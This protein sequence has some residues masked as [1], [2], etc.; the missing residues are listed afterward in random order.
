MTTSAQTAPANKYPVSLEDEDDDIFPPNPYNLSKAQ[1]IRLIDR[2]HQA[3]IKANG[4]PDLDL[5][6]RGMV[7]ESIREPWTEAAIK[8]GMRRGSRKYGTIPC[9]RS[10]RGKNCRVFFRELEV[11]EWFETNVKPILEKSATH[12]HH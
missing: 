5:D 4:L 11:I 9:L 2:L 7:E 6:Y 12:I 3:V 8:R 10:P 1:A